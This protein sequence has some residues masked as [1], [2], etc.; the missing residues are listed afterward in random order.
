M[1]V[2]PGAI[3]VSLTVALPI[4]RSADGAD[5]P[6]VMVVEV[7]LLPGTGSGVVAL[8]VAALVMS[9]PFPV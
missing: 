7:L 5:T 6:L 9:V 2:W 4:T 8:T 1:N 3:W